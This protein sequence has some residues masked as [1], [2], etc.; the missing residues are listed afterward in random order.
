MSGGVE[1]WDPVEEGSPSRRKMWR[2][3]QVPSFGGVISEPVKSTETKQSTSALDVQVGGGHYKEFPIQPIEFTHR[4]GLNFCQ[5][6]VIKYITRYKHK[7]G[8]EDLKKVKHYVD[9]LMELEYGQDESNL[10]RGIDTTDSDMG[11]WTGHN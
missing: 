2:R 4:N 11:G 5:G 7:G 9:L 3:R 10:D 8:I 1:T 6:N